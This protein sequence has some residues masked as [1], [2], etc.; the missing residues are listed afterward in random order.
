MSCLLYKK[1]S[2]EDELGMVELCSMSE[3]K[4]YK[5]TLIQ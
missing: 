2:K 5:K 3:T 1:V 4:K